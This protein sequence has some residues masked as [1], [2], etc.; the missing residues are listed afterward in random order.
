MHLDRSAKICERINKENKICE[1]IIR[2]SKLLKKKCKEKR[3]QD[4][5]EIIIVVV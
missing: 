1:M 2:V 5:I 4:L 3:S